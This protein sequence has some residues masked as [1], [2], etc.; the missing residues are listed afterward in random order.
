VSNETASQFIARMKLQWRP[1]TTAF[2]Y[3]GPWKVEAQ[4][5]REQTGYP[6]YVSSVE[7]LR[8]AND[9]NDV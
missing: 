9:G 4:T 8:S 7:R 5:L 1:R 2:G 3:L 6:D